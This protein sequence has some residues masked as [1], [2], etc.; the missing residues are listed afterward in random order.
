MTGIWFWLGLV[1]GCII[2][3]GPRVALPSETYPVSR[4]TVS[5]P[6]LADKADAIVLA[7]LEQTQ[8]PG[9]AVALVRDG[10][11]VLASGYGW[12][13]LEAERLMTPTTP[14]LLSS[15]S[16]TFVGIAAMQ[17]VEAQRVTLEDAASDHLPFALDN[18][19]VDGETITLRH[20]LTHNSGI[21]DSLAYHFSYDEGDPVV[22][23]GE[24]CEGYL[25]KGGDFWR[26][27][28]FARRDP[29]TEFA[30]SNVG[31]AT[32]ALALGTAANLEF[33]DLVR[34]DI[35]EPLGMTQTAYLLEDLTDPPAVPYKTTGRQFRPYEAYG[36]PTY[37]DGLAR[38]S[39][40]DMARYASMILGNGE[41]D[42][43]VVLSPDGVQQ[44][45]EV[46]PAY[47]TDESGQAIAWAQREVNE[48]LLYGHNGGDYGS[49]T[50]LWLDTETGSGVVLLMHARPD[51]FTEFL[52]VELRLL[53]LLDQ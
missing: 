7:Y 53:D 21:E 41:L 20:L 26:S 48:R 29:G 6:A 2:E 13:D 42:G 38:S 44:L 11:P 40:E 30:Y 8:L 10:Q 28:N 19:K 4:G 22:A 36:Y 39:A 46:D 35:W 25:L 45:L 32:A 34:R 49:F 37:P 50:E 9:L 23:L 27:G 43:E 17:A 33:E 51:E 15:V 14:V 47:G 3:K 18:P 24:F 1:S 12:A 52:R 31:M 5:D 16:K